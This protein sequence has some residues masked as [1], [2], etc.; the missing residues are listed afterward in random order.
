MTT[1]WLG[2]DNNRLLGSKEYGGSAALPIWIDYMEAALADKSEVHFEQPEGIVSVKIDP[3]TGLLARP[4]QRNAI[5]EIFQSELAPSEETG[6][7]AM[8]ATE[9]GLQDVLEEDIF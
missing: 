7:D 9:S 6:L 5:F 4:G 1:T 8:I 2:F 3:N